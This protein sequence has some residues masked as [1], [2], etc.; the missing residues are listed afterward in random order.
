MYNMYTA[1]IN[2]GRNA[3][4]SDDVRNVKRALGSIYKFTPPLPMDK[5]DR[6]LKNDHC[7]RL[8]VSVKHDVDDPE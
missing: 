6:G 8:L 2:E 4:R 7:L 3:G 1:Q 5:S